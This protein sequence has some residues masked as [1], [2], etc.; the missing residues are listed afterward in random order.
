LYSAR[1][2]GSQTE[3]KKKLP[4]A[5]GPLGK[6]GEKRKKHHAMPCVKPSRNEKGVE[7]GGGGKNDPFSQK[8]KKGN[9]R[10]NGTASCT[11]GKESWGESPTKGPRS[12]TEIS[13][14]GKQQ[15]R[16]RKLRKGMASEKGRR[17]VWTFL[18][19]PIS[20]KRVPW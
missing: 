11:E 18:P 6:L 17:G 16:I 15:R 3:R 4:P 19:N 13:S 8:K 14:R 5:R 2:G 9:E 20:G 12:R 1:G 10:E 7:C